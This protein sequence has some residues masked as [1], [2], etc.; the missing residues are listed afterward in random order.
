M[1]YVPGKSKVRGLKM[2]RNVLD[3]ARASWTDC[4]ANV[5]MFLPVIVSYLQGYRFLNTICVNPGYKSVPEF[6]AVILAGV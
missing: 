3:D 5:T 6:R 1:A 4:R 2:R